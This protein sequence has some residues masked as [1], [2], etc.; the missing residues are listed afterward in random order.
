MRQKK[1]EQ[2]GKKKKTKKEAQPFLPCI[3]LM[4]GSAHLSTPSL[5]ES[6]LKGCNWSKT[7]ESL[8]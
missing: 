4:Q 5:V 1:V 8:C 2:K 3:R 7:L 6:E